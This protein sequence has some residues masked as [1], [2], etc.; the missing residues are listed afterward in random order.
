MNDQLFPALYD[1]ADHASNKTQ[2]TFVFITKAYLTLVVISVAL[3]FFLPK[4]SWAAII[5]AAFLLITM[6]APVFMMIM[7]YSDTWYRARALAESIKTSTWKF[8]MRS[9]PFDIPD[10]EAKAHFQELLRKLLGEHR[11]LG[12]ALGGEA[13]MRQVTPTMEEMRKAE[14]DARR[15]FYL[16]KR[17]GEQHGWYCKKTAQNKRSA[18]FW[19]IF[20][21][22]FHAIAVVF[23]LVQISTPERDLPI[24]LFIVLGS[25][26]LSWMQF[27]KFGELGAAYALTAHEI[28]IAGEG[29]SGV[30]NEEEF[31]TVVADIENAFSR[32]HTQWAARKDKQ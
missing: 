21:L 8:M 29:L 24:E 31:S 16:D 7:K 25:S 26:A 13:K 32:E 27:K 4:T 2:T 5:T 9:E 12:E 17:V 23:A 30:S 3:G 22:T 1:A 20:M 18:R 15:S 10:G 6:L 14:L 28:S 19:L 11:A